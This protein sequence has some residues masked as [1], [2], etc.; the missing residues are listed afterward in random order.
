MAPL[1]AA[2]RDEQQKVEK[3]RASRSKTEPPSI[4]GRPEENPS[5]ALP[6]AIAG[7][8]RERSLSP[9]SRPR[10][11]Y[12]FVADRLDNLRPLDT[13]HPER[14]GHCSSC[15]YPCWRCTSSNSPPAP[16]VWSENQVSESE[17]MEPPSTPASASLATSNKKRKTYEEKG[18]KY[19]GPK[20]ADFEMCILVPCG[21]LLDWCDPPQL[22]PTA[23]FGSQSSAPPSRV[24]IHKTEEELE[25]IMED[26]S[27]YMNRQ[28]DEHALT[29][30]CTD[31]IVLRDRNKYNHPFEDMEVIKAERRD[32]WKPRKEGPI[33]DGL[34]VYDWDLEPD[35]TYTVS[36]RI[37]DASDRR[38]LNS[39]SCQRWLAERNT[40]CPYL[41]IEYKSSEKTGKISHATNQIAAASMLWLHQRKQIR[42]TLSKSLDD[43][44]HYSITLFDA[45]YTISETKFRGIQ[46]HLRKLAEG[47]LTKINDLK[48]YIAWSNAIHT[49]GLGSNA[50]SFKKDIQELLRRERVL[51]SLPTPEATHQATNS[52]DPTPPTSQ[53]N[54]HTDTPH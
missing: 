12:S 16:P 30:T 27:E 10:K 39:I 31:S 1:G 8:K 17:S 47:K 4:T 44:R 40:V 43:L 7:Q 15:G 35:A 45:S 24:F 46:Y 14:N 6:R 9:Q 2:H 50:T 48:E 20:D 49:W 23:V 13:P 41:T 25:D 33:P 5:D 51:Q 28:Y 29:M 38:M 42:N 19:V 26:F 11:R 52:S 36:I 54:V 22:T 32:K 37:F 21:L 18:L 53:D 3:L 34:H